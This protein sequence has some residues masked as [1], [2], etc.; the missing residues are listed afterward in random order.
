MN[1][2]PYVFLLINLVLLLKNIYYYFWKRK[3]WHGW[4]TLHNEWHLCH[5]YY[6]WPIWKDSNDISIWC[7]LC[8]SEMNIIHPFYEENH[9]ISSR[10]STQT[11]QWACFLTSLGFHSSR[12]SFF[13]KE[14]QSKRDD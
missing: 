8:N 14:R 11:T 5:F 10:L 7:N 13:Y 3:L 9:D 2:L 6:F 12:S 1:E 4:F